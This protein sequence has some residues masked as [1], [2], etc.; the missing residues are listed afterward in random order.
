MVANSLIGSRL[1]YGNSLLLG[2]PA[3]LLRR[4]QVIQNTMA[5]FMFDLH[6][7][8][9]ETPLDRPLHWLPVASRVQFMALCLA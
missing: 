4:L 5:F 1:D 9:H 6:Y 7:G 2:I 3:Y 8:T